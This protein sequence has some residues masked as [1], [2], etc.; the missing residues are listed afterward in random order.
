MKKT[1]VIFLVLLLTGCAQSQL[2][3]DLQPESITEARSVSESGEEINMHISEQENSES[4]IQD[5]SD[6][7]KTEESGEPNSNNG[8]ESSSDTPYNDNSD[9]STS[10]DRGGWIDLPTFYTLEDFENYV[11]YNSLENLK[12]DEQYVYDKYGNGYY[13][14]NLKYFKIPIDAYIPL[15]EILPSVKFDS[16]VLGGNWYIYNF[17]NDGDNTTRY[18]CCVYYDKSYCGL[19]ILEYVLSK[20]PNYPVNTTPLKSFDEAEIPEKGY[21]NVLFDIDGRQVIYHFHNGKASSINYIKGPF[22]I[23]IDATTFIEGESKWDTTV[24]SVELNIYGINNPE[25]ANEFFDRLDAIIE[26]KMK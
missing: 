9:S 2:A 17:K 14:S 16:V 21:K 23:I 6:D 19:N 8:N 22:E 11:L 1:I 18:G 12:Q 10:T 5:T 13:K 3:P 4:N 15:N 24:E 7:N 26:E 25:T 20:N